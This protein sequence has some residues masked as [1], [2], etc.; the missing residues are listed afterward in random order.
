LGL[1]RRHLIA[2]GDSRSDFDLFRMSGLSI[3]INGTPEAINEAD[4]SI[5]VRDLRE[6]VPVA[7]AYSNRSTPPPDDEARTPEFGATSELVAK[8][9]LRASRRA[10]LRRRRDR[11]MCWAKVARCPC[12]RSVSS[13]AADERF[14]QNDLRGPSNTT[15]LWLPH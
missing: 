4:V 10:G 7:V 3:A 5:D 2:I 15:E 6:V 14:G 1:S 13:T 11:T 12:R 9:D 8:C